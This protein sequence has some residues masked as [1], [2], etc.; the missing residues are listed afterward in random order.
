MEVLDM[1]NLVNCC[2][3]A[4]VNRLSQQLKYDMWHIQ[5]FSSW[6]KDL[7]IWSV[8]T[9]STA[10][11]KWI[12]LSS[13]WK[14]W[15]CHTSYLSCWLNRLTIARATVYEIQHTSATCHNKKPGHNEDARCCHNRGGSTLHKNLSQWPNYWRSWQGLNPVVSYNKPY[16]LKLPFN[17]T[18]ACPCNQANPSLLVPLSNERLKIVGPK[19]SSNNAMFHATSSFRVQPKLLRV[20]TLKTT[21]KEMPPHIILAFSSPSLS[22]PI[23]PVPVCDKL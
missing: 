6:R 2:A 18:L 17:T 5:I 8:R 9:N 15:I 21:I 10:R 4:I 23:F 20:Y 22:S 13:R 12:N 1:L 7:I 14:I 3:R 16:N 19:Y 11:S